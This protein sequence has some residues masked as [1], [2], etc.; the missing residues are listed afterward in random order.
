MGLHVSLLT[1]PK[2]IMGLEVEHILFHDKNRIYSVA[3]V[4]AAKSV[5]NVSKQG[6]II[7]TSNFIWR[8]SFQNSE[9]LS[10]S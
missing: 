2:A 6:G 10:E 8:N 9:R 4:N 1:E 3:G 5:G 7:M